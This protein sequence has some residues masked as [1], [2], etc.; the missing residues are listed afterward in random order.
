M[1]EIII[2]NFKAP[3]MNELMH[4]HWTLHSR[5]MREMKALVAGET[6]AQV[7]AKD[8]KGNHFAGGVAVFI[9]AEYKGSNRRDTDNLYVKPIL[10]GLVQAGLLKDD[11]C[12]IVKFVGISVRRNSESDRV[13][14]VVSDQLSITY[15]P[16]CTNSSEN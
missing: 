3:S 5:W 11:N 7:K 1:I 12:E 10:D 2:N 4:K 8:R 15:P 6:M 13:R 9:E 16:V 14:I